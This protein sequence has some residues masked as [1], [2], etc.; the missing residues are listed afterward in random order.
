M[1]K[2]ILNKEIELK[3]LDK[4]SLLGA[5]ESFMKDI[6][7]NDLKIIDTLA[8]KAYDYKDLLSKAK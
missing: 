4:N 5:K 2:L 1:I 3:S 8:Y 7:E 6:S